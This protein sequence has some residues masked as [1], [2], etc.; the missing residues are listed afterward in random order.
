MLMFLE[1]FTGTLL[2]GA[3]LWAYWRVSPENIVFFEK[4]CRNRI[5]GLAGALP[6]AWLCV[7]LARP[8][9]PEFLQAFLIPAA[10]IIPIASTF[11][12]DY[13]AS[14]T[15]AFW[16]ILFAYDTVNV[17]F[18]NRI[19]GA[20]VYAVFSWI[21]GIAGIWISAKPCTLR[22]TLRL[23]VKKS[24]CRKVFIAVA[25]AGAIIMICMTVGISGELL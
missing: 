15:I 4:L 6:A 13:Y 19:P 18:I 23:S 17:S 9:T 12:V 5:I 21:L 22:D 2:Y 16:M 10:F 20:S 24:W 3:L 11:Y 14:R 8:V 25:A 1:F 7:A